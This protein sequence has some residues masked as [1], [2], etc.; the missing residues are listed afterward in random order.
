MQKP[1]NLVFIGLPGS[2][3]GTQIET[4]KDKFNL[5]GLSTGEI[6]RELSEKKSPLGNKIKVTINKGDLMPDQILTEVIK[7]KIES[8]SKDKG[9]VFDGFP[10]TLKQAQ[11]LDEILFRVGRFL[12][13]AIYL[14]VPEDELEKRLSTRLLCEN[15]GYS[16]FGHEK[17]CP[18]CGSKLIKREDDSPGIMRKRIQRDIDNIS[19]VVSYY[20]GRGKLI[21]INGDQLPKDVSFDIV[22]AL[23]DEDDKDKK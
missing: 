18:R 14:I 12:D 20:E 17:K 19:S 21:E 5:T 2:G 16:A 8:V 7:S 11:L 3:K 15:C 13:K 6:A 9:L 22:K 1:L 10:R 23:E 4:V